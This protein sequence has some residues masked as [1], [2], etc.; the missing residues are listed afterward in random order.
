MR[1][2]NRATLRSF[3]ERRP[4]AHRPL[5]DWLRIVTRA[6]WTGPQDI[7]AIIRSADF[8]GD[9]VVFN[10]GG[11]KYRLVVE[12]RYRSRFVFVCFIGTHAEYDR[13][14]VRTVRIK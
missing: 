5:L 10:I 13:V 2:F 4:E 11:N 6:D 1:L 8:V 9:R 3:W 7:K 12:I 14:D